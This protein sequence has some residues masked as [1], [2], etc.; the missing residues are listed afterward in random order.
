M[1]NCLNNKLIYVKDEREDPTMTIHIVY[2][3]KNFHE[4]EVSSFLTDPKCNSLHNL[5]YIV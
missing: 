5:M 1:N 3:D 4:L 2:M